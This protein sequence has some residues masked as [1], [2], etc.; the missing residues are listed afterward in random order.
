MSAFTFRIAATLC[1]AWSAV[2]HAEGN[3]LAGC[4]ALWE[5]Q[6]KQ[7]RS[8]KWTVE[9]TIV[10]WKKS[11][12]ACPDQHAFNYRLGLLYLLNNQIEDAANVVRLIGTKEREDLSLSVEYEKQKKR[13]SIDHPYFARQ[14]AEVA[15]RHPTWAIVHVKLAYF[16][17]KSGQYAEA[18]TA[19]QHAEGIV[20]S[21]NA[22]RLDAM[23]SFELRDYK[24]TII[25][26]NH[27]IEIQPSMQADPE[28]MFRVSDACINTGDLDTA[29]AAL[30][31]LLAANP[32]IANNP[33]F[34][35]RRQ[36]IAELARARGAKPTN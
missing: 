24:R 27:A 21:P 18:R 28:L 16:C 32:R 1:L 10:N 2:A 19:A 23:A 29:D 12:A 7:G 22:Y 20:P 5:R 36:R 25:I 34:A 31:L 35:S 26:G 4:D 8:E 9:Q 11:G 6:D 30:T 14:Y 33:D 13:G 3:K 17:F 15:K